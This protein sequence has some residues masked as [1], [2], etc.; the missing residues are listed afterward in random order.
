MNL[1]NIIY[2]E[3]INKISFIDFDKLIIDRSRKDDKKYS[4]NVLSKFKSSLEK[5][6]LNMR[7]DWKK[8]IR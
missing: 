5:L 6:N 1:K 4:S 3:S 7:F 2:N 8:F